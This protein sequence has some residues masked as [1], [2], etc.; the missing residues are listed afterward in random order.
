[1]KPFETAFS[2]LSDAVRS[3]A[4]P[5]A[6]AAVGIGDRLLRQE[7]FGNAQLYPTVLPAD[8]NTR[9]DMASL[10]KILSTT[11]VTFRLIE[12]GRL[13]LD[14]T[15]GRFLEVPSD[16]AEITV[17]QLLTHTS[18]FAPHMDLEHCAPSPKEA[19]SFILSEP[20]TYTPGTQ[21][22][23]S[24]MGYIVLGKLLEQVGGA[25]LDQLAQKYVFSPL[26]MTHT[27]YRPA[28]D[29]FA[30]TEKLSDATF[31]SGVV[32]D[33]NARFLGG[34]S[35]NAGLF[36]DL[37]DVT[38]F[39]SMLACGGRHK[40]KYFLSPAMLQAALHN[41]TPGMA[42]NRGLGFFLKTPGNFHGDLVSPRSYGHTGFTGTT[43][44]IDP[45]TGLYAVLLSNRVHPTRE[46]TRFL[47]VRR[48]F[49]NAIAAELPRLL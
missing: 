46:N 34:V 17:Q 22:A 16:K 43:L 38:I 4:A 10:T 29:N 48:V 28:G 12:V 41:Y 39:A 49:H 47:R 15:L 30:A 5:C 32:H 9:F 45:A 35:G 33:E 21:E 27:G 18:G 1:M 6:A 44:L 40:G 31:L 14:D 26:G 2:L 7:V 3:G 37:A 23:Y 24:C 42:E 8:Q 19:L 25:P 36:S 13:C 20:L 11:T